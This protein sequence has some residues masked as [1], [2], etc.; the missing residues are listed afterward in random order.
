LGFS[1]YFAD[2]TRACDIKKSFV[3]SA[4]RHPAKAALVIR[5]QFHD[6]GEQQGGGG[7][8]RAQRRRVPQLAAERK[9]AKV[10][11]EELK[12]NNNLV[13]QIRNRKIVNFFELIVY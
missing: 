8:E 10:L 3:H 7:R 2:G 12:L 1:G 4:G 6:D 11:A 5:G 9:A 13:R